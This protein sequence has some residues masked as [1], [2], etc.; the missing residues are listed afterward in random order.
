MYTRNNKA[1]YVIQITERKGQ[2]KGKLTQSQNYTRRII[3]RLEKEKWMMIDWLVKLNHE[4]RR[5]GWRRWV[6]NKGSCGTSDGGGGKGKATVKPKNQKALGTHTNTS[7][8]SSCFHWCICSSSECVKGC[9]LC[10]SHLE[11]HVTAITVSVCTV[12]ECGFPDLS[13]KFYLLCYVWN[14]IPC[15]KCRIWSAVLSGTEEKG[16]YLGCV[17]WCICVLKDCHLCQVICCVFDNGCG[18]IYL[19]SN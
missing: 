13:V 10:T 18:N 3:Q 1:L 15:V 19:Y 17:T 8:N 7:A 12:C 16:C 11:Y 2:S 6:V 4:Q 5:W 9:F 14:L